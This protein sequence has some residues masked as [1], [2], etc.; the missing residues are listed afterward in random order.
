M[1]V[2]LPRRVILGFLV[3]CACGCPQLGDPKK[4]NVAVTRAQALVV[5][6]GDPWILHHDLSW[7]RLVFSCVRAGG[8]RGC[9]CVLFGVGE[10]G[11][12]AG[13]AA[14]D[15][16]DAGSA[17]GQESALGAGYGVRSWVE[18]FYFESDQPSRVAL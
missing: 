12:P 13:D 7:R 6:V 3:P 8:Y 4:F 1:R 17:E 14:G 9:G 16:E 15:D 2:G 10:D 5:V 11:A 18:S